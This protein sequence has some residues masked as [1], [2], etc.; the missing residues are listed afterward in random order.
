MDF[1][2]DGV[3]FAF[4]TVFY[5]CFVGCNGEML[6]SDRKSTTW[7]YCGVQPALRPFL[8]CFF[9][10]FYYILLDVSDFI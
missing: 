9:L 1:S 7:I 3:A 8:F 4:Y 6:R 2:Y 10:G 5:Y